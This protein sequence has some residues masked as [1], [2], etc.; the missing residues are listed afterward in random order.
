MKRQRRWLT[1]TAGLVLVFLGRGATAQNEK[2]V[3]RPAAAGPARPED[4]KAIRAA[5]AAFAK[6]FQAGDAKAVAALFT[7]E[8]DYVDED[9]QMFRGRAAI[10]KE[11][12]T[13]F[14]K[15]KGMT[16]ES[17]VDSLRFLGADVAVQN[18]VCRVKPAGGGR[19]NATRFTA[20]LVK[21]DG[22]WLL[23]NVRESPYVPECNYEHL[24]ELEWL[25]GTWS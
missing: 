16:L 8:A 11:F 24:S 23:E 13:A 12:A 6:A 10:E 3:P 18:G 5:G 15:Q 9:G 20:V 17:T 21:R 7:P 1:L 19:G 14:L 22:A 4:E 25:V 2:I